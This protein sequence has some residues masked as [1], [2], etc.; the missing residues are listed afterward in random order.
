MLTVDKFRLCVT[1]GRAY[2]D[3]DHVDRILTVLWPFQLGEGGA[4]G[5]DLLC[6]RWVKAR[7]LCAVTTYPAEWDAYGKSAGPVRNRF[8]LDDFK[9][10]ML[11]A[12][13]GGA[14]T[15]DCIRAAHERGIPVW[16]V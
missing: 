5:A 6:K 9:P 13:P 15:A 2:S 12:F 3:T 8:M 14:G 1:G 7:A 11:V 4:H 10:H 16:C